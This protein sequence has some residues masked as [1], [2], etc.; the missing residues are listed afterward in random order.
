MKKILTKIIT[1]AIAPK[2]DLG[3]LFAQ[4]EKILKNANKKPLRLILID[5]KTK[6]AKILA[7]FIYEK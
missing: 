2:N 3:S 6:K 1:V 7:S 5:M 4:A